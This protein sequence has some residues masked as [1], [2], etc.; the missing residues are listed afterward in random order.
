MCKVK[1]TGTEGN[2]FKFSVSKVETAIN[3][4]FNLTKLLAI[5]KYANLQF[6]DIMLYTSLKSARAVFFYCEMNMQKGK[7]ERAV[8]SSLKDIMISSKMPSLQISGRT[9]AQVNKLLQ[10]ISLQT[11]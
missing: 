3:V 10:I 6:S 7:D 4:H 11:N 2:F 1:L 8:S 9:I 5:N